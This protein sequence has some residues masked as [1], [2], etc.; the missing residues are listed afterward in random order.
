VDGKIDALTRGQEALRSQVAELNG[1]VEQQHADATAKL[2]LVLGF[3]GSVRE[4]PTA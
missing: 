1:K 4:S 2:D 3:L